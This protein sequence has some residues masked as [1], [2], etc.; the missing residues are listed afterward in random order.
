MGVQLPSTFRT[1]QMWRAIAALLVVFFHNSCSIFSLKKYWDYDP[2]H[3]FFNFG[4]AG[5]GL[6]F[7]LS[8]FIIFYVHWNDIHCPSRLFVFLKKRFIRIYPI[9]WLILL[10]ITVIYFLVPLFGLGFER[11]GW[12]IASSF[13]L[14]HIHSSNTILVVAWTLYHEVLFY[15]LF[16][17]LI[18]DKRVGTAVLVI[19]FIM[20]VF[21]FF[22]PYNGAEY[23]SGNAFLFSSSHLL[24]LLG[25]AAC[26]VVKS[27][28]MSIRTAWVLLTIG[29]LV[30]IGLG[31]E[32]DYIGSIDPSL[33][34]L[35]YGIASFMMLVG[36]VELER[37]GPF[38]VPKLLQ[39]IGDAS[40]SIY[41]IHFPA[42]SVLAKLFSKPILKDHIPVAISY[43]LMSFLV[44]YGGI[45]MHTL[46][47]KPMLNFLAKKL[48]DGK[49]SLQQDM[50][51]I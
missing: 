34:N 10:P 23:D 32:E 47:E 13:A 30:F 24:F 36:G 5:V 51:K 26:W 16:S 22:Q 28:I 3:S 21:F 42:L 27:G 41:L 1:L 48:R 14:I 7:V 20:S 39:L 8:G 6:F 17:I 45:I 4:S 44:V 11:E 12:T 18:L 43:I 25:M 50:P 46:I 35:F 2:L 31:M 9:Y 19:W 29:I 49:A 40:Y 33:R 15:F 38:R 37:I